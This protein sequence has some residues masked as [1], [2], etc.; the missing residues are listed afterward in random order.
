MKEIIPIPKNEYNLLNSKNT[1]LSLKLSR[2]ISWNFDNDSV[3]KKIDIVDKVFDTVD[4]QRIYNDLYVAERNDKIWEYLESKN[5]EGLKGIEITAKTI[6]PLI[7]GLGSE[8]VLET[9]L[10]LDYNSGHPIIPASSIKGIL[11]LATAIMIAKQNNVTEVSDEELAKLWGNETTRGKIIIFDAIA[12]LPKYNL[13]MMNVH[14]ADYYSGNGQPDGQADPNPIKYLVVSEGTIFKFFFLFEEFE[15]YSVSFFEN[16]VTYAFSELG[17]GGKAGIGYGRFKIVDDGIKYTNKKT[18][19]TEDIKGPTNCDLKVETLTKQ[20]KTKE[21]QIY[22]TNINKKVSETIASIK[23]VINGKKVNLEI[24]ILD[25][26]N[27]QNA[28]QKIRVRV[29]EIITTDDNGK[30]NISYKGEYVGKVE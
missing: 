9:G 28:H 14:Y 3:A 2:M 22:E 8:S 5:G 19:A 15:N 10:I 21:L 4:K 1:N 16:V 12:K 18:N 11:R 17:F 20:V 25:L 24:E 29:F 26:L 7:V 30:E 13:D 23:I 6:S 27:F